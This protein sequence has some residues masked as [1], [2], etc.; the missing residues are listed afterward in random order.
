MVWFYIYEPDREELNLLFV[1][2]HWNR[3]TERVI[4]LNGL[5]G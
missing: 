3:N 1:Q 2:F 5:K 4:L